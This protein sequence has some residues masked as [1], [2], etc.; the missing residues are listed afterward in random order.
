MPAKAARPRP[1][2]SADDI[3]ETAAQ[4]I[5]T[6]GVEALTMRGLAERMGVA[7][8]SI[9]WHVGGRDALFDALTERLVHRIAELPVEGT[10][11]VERIRSLARVHRRALIDNQHLLAVAHGRNQTSALFSPIQQALAT[12]LGDI[13]VT[14]RD[15]ALVL[16]TIEVHVIASALMQFSSIRGQTRRAADPWNDTWPDRELV[17]ALAQPTDYDAVFDYGLDALLARLPGSA[18]AP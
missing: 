8:T 4:M 2:V 12:E 14:G 10:T 3:L 11:P 17:G 15:A 13:G 7:V 18:A 6:A 9:Y 1:A 16:R 5:E